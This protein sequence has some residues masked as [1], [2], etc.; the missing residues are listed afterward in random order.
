MIFA[1]VKTRLQLVAFLCLLTIYSGFHYYLLCIV[2]FEAHTILR[3]STLLLTLALQVMTIIMLQ[4]W[5]LNCGWIQRPQWPLW[6][7]IRF[8]HSSVWRNYP[9][10]SWCLGSS[11]LQ[12]SLSVNLLLWRAKTDLAWVTDLVLLKQLCPLVENLISIS[13]KK[14]NP[15][16]VYIIDTK[17]PMFPW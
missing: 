7:C 1:F 12:N 4:A 11:S 16:A 14:K 8:F 2:V 3:Y 6:V 5:D 9:I 15:K 10:S 17:F 13:N